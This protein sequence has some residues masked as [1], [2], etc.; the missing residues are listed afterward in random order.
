VVGNLTW[1]V[2]KGWVALSVVTALA[3]VGAVVFLTRART[4]P[5]LL[6]QF[7]PADVSVF[8]EM[9]SLS[10]ALASM[11]TVTVADPAQ[12]DLASSKRELAREIAGSLHVS[13]DEADAMAQA[14]SGAAF[15]GRV[16][17]QELHSAW[18]VAF[19]SEAPVLPLLASNRLTSEGA[20]GQGGKAFH[21]TAV[22]ALKDAP[23]FAAWLRE[24]STTTTARTLA[25]LPSARLLLLGDSH[26]LADIAAVAEVGKP[27]LENHA[28]FQLARAHQPSDGAAAIAFA[29]THA[30]ADIPALA[31]DPL[32][33]SYIHDGGPVT[34]V[35]RFTPAGG[36]VSARFSVLGA[37]APRLGAVAAQA[38]KLTLVDRLPVETVAY[39]ALATRAVV[40]DPMAAK[41]ALLAVA[42]TAHHLTGAD[43][44]ATLAEL[45]RDTGITLDEL[46]AS[47][48]DEAAFGLL[49]EPGVKYGTSLAHAALEGA[50]AFVVVG[51]DDHAAAERTV[52]KLRSTVEKSRLASL[53]TITPDGSGFVATPG[54]GARSQLSGL[55]GA[56]LPTLRVRCVEKLVVVVVAPP[57]L[58]TRM[59]ASLDEGIDTLKDSPAHAL[60]MRTLHAGAHGYAWVD[61]GRLASIVFAGNPNVAASAKARGL[62]IDSLVLDGPS[63]LTTA[64]G[65]DVHEADGTAVLDVETL[66][67]GALALLEG[68]GTSPPRKPP[69]PLPALLASSA[70]ERPADAS[71]PALDDMPLCTM[72]V[73]TLEHCATT[74]AAPETKQSFAARAAESRATYQATPA[75]KRA[76]TNASCLGVLHRLRKDPAC[77]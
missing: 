46:V 62:P 9:P 16:E 3:V 28:G 39:V 20:F 72:V 17:G 61:T 38:S 56:T 77:K 60:A 24:V 63:R 32:L 6:A 43:I 25:W 47:A 45:E 13:G 50:G 75:D 57:A 15:V 23:L 52:A 18:V 70:A 5:A 31:S 7:A 29:D 74:A 58:V 35:A 22:P 19:T 37:T 26:L 2:V 68:L 76:V 59:F 42:Q 33:A 49:A 44:S 27:S 8:V 10:F 4:P 41:S 65:L 54:D 12:V 53:A 67:L 34:G 48:G 30:L 1:N 55:Y 40:K 21:V 71:V 73:G 66:N 69:P 14:V 64:F 51:A 11:A 36:L